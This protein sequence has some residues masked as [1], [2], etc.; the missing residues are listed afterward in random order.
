[1][2][3]EVAQ[4]KAERIILV[5]ANCRPDAFAGIALAGFYAS[6]KLAIITTEYVRS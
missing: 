6:P 3:L 2:R 4:A 5:L 1:M